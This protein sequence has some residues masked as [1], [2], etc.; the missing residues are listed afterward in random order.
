MDNFNRIITILSI[1][2]RFFKTPSTE[3]LNINNRKFS[4]VLQR[5]LFFHFAMKYKESKLR[6]FDLQWHIKK[7]LGIKYPKTAIIQA[8]STVKKKLEIDDVEFQRLYEELDEEIR[9][10]LEIDKRPSYSK[11]EKIKIL[12]QS[13]GLSIARISETYNISYNK[14]EKYING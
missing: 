2:V 14:I 1:V 4:Q 10:S 6:A 8:I 7:R 11:M 13:T 3:L 9:Y 5:H 12:Y